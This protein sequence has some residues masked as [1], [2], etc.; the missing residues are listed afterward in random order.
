M[1]DSGAATLRT[2]DDLRGPAGKLEALLNTG[3]PDAAMA[4]LVCHPHP[5]GGGTMHN[6]VV[7]HAMKALQTLGL[8]VLRF[9]F[10]GTGLSDGT[11]DHGHGEQDDVRAAVDWLDREFGLPVLCAGFS[12]GAAVG[13]RACCGDPRVQG[14]VALGLPTHAEGRDYHYQFLQSCPQPKLFISGTMDQFAPRKQLEAVFD[15]VAP[16]VEVVWVEGAEH[17]FTGKLDEVQLAIRNW[18][19]TYLLPTK[20]S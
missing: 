13:L 10:R 19:Q 18:V 12:F 17:F 7:Y 5:L 9:N 4:A 2:I 14:L 6:K 11:H 16:P 15:E 20:V 8:P 3:G 1:A